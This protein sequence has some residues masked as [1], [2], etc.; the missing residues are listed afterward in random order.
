MRLLEVNTLTFTEFYPPNI[1]KY[2]IASHRWV[3]GTEV[4]LSSVQDGKEKH[5]LGYQK[6]K[7]FAKYVR[8]QIPDLKWLWIDTCCIN[9][10]SDREL[11]EAINSMFRW[12]RDAEVCLAY[13]QDV[14]AV[15]DAAPTFEKSTWFSRGWTLQ[16]LLAPA[17]VI[18]LSEDWQVI[19]H[20]GK[21]RSS[22]PMQAGTPLESRIAN[23]TG[24]PESIL[25]DYDKS[26][27]LS[28]EE[29]LKWMEHR[30][31]T[32]EEDSSYCL[33]GILGVGM[34]IRYGEGREKTRERLLKKARLRGRDIVLGEN[35]HGIECGQNFGSIYFASKQSETRPK[36]SSNIPFR[37]D[38]N[39]VKRA[40]L[41]NQIR[42]KLLAPAGR[43]ALVGLGGVG[44][45]QLAIEYAHQ[46]RQQS[47]QTWMFWVHAS[48]TARFEQSMRDVANQLGID[49]R[50]D[51]DVD[52]LQLLQNW[53]RNESK[54]NWFMVLDNADDASFLL[55]PLATLGTAQP[56]RSR[57]G[58]IPSCDH[59]SVMITTRSEGEALKLVYKTE[60]L[61]VSPM[62]EEE[63]EELLESK[64]G[65]PSPHNRNL[66]QALDCIPLAISQAAAYIQERAP[67]CSVQQYREEIER[68]R[69]SRSSLLRRHIPLPDR[70]LEATNAVML[71]WQIS[72]E[73]IY[74]TQRSAAELLSTMS[75][76]DRLGIPETLLRADVGNSDFSITSSV[77]EDD[78]VTLRNFSFVSSTIDPQSWEM[79]R[80]VQDATQAWLADRGR[81][82]E[83]FSRFI[84]H[85]SKLFP[86]GEF[87][88]RPLCRM[89]F[90]HA[91][92]AAEQKPASEST[93]IEWALLMYNLAWYTL[94]QGDYVNA[95]T[96]AMNS[97]TAR[98]EQLGGE[99]G[100]TLLSIEM[101]AEQL[102]VKV[103][104]M[105]KAKLGPDHPS[106]LTSMNNLAALYFDQERWAEAEEL[107]RL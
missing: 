1:P 29:K 21:P 30:Q 55:E 6:V 44:K 99:D 106:T 58:Y 7:G 56:T 34:N 83:V 107:H 19:G 96:T 60:V 79:H 76:C 3:A 53:L 50:Q 74:R 20:K 66:V 33:L 41:T 45:S 78:I 22:V 72:F 95:L 35:H 80:L 4:M 97:M 28:T 2:A 25:Q 51:P 70:D 65:Q 43:V 48:N 40:T 92:S 68:S 12:Y 27:S 77:F 59:G 103:M 87:E 67:R 10:H 46:L 11:S 100:L 42:Q 73:H 13:L 5:S 26:H 86:S 49:E 71:T 39:F 61:S 31:T 88:N 9:Q 104:E 64:L 90:P 37:R 91:M 89:L 81:F 23:I 102:E 94:Q 105:S 85:L 93:Q 82:D 17:I 98:S 14:P 32:R 101:D 69:V 57:I 62:S 75:L 18:F 52:Y 24:I 15:T 47:P 54:G 36:P 38:A 16:E 63:A 8:T 84:H